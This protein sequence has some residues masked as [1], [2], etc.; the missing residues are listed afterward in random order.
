[1]PVETVLTHDTAA[2]S[3]IHGSHDTR[4]VVVGSRGH[5]AVGGALLGS[6]GLHLLH[7]ADCPVLIVHEAT[8]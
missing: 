8:A 2:S 4:L 5:G 1:M 6:V 3:L 7:H